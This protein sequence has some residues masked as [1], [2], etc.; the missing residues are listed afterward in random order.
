M[1]NAG[2]LASARLRAR[3]DLVLTSGDD[4]VVVKDPLT[5]E[6]F[7]LGDRER[8]LLEELRRP[9]SLAELTRRFRERFPNERASGRQVMSFCSALAECSLLLI[10]GAARTGRSEAPKAPK[11]GVAWHSL[12]SPL[13]IRLPGFDPT[14]LLNAT[15][16]I[17]RL[18][19]SWAFVALLSI[20]V[21]LVGIAWIGAANEVTTEL[22]RLVDLFQPQHA[23]L[24][25]GAVIITKTWHELG[26][27]LACRRMGAE[28]HE[29]G[30]MLLAFMPCLY[31]DVSDA[32]TLTSRRRRVLV[33]LGGVYFEFLLA[34]AAAGAWLFLAPGPLR[35][36]SMYVVVT[37]TISTLLINLNPLLRFDGYYVLADAWGVS[38]L[39]QRSREALWGGVQRWIRA[40]P[41]TAETPDASPTLLAAY[42]LASTIYSWCL[43]GVI[44]WAVYLGLEAAGFA[45]VGDLLLVLS[46]GGVGLAGVRSARRV[47]PRGHGRS[48]WKPLLRVTLVAALSAGAIAAVLA[49]PLEQSLR[50]PC[51][52]ES[53]SFAEVVARRDGL[54]KPVAAYGDRVSAGALLAQQTDPT[55]EWRRLELI[56]REA[57]LVAQIDGL[58]TR[59][60][61]D[62]QFL[63]EI[64]RLRPTLAEVRRQLRTHK[65][66]A[67]SLTLRA[68]I[69]GRVLPPSER[70][71][72]SI[73]EQ[74]LPTWSGRPLDESNAGCLL[75]SGEVLCRVM[76]DGLRA[77]VLLDEHDCG[78]LNLGDLVRV[79]LHRDPGSIL[80]GHVEQIAPATSDERLSDT[81]MALEQG[82]R[83]SL[84]KGSAYRVT[85][86]IES[87]NAA[88][89]P[90][91]LGTARL[92]TG[93]ETVG[94][95]CLRWLRRVIR[96][97]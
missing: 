78:L 81:E 83:S 13:A 31:C 87:I 52:L 44:L 40:E 25:I 53:E 9:L 30:V 35:V 46:F 8:F 39:H 23:L 79:A 63:S 12:L 32:W 34:L 71:A 29:I 57:T 47:V 6:Y 1:A 5:L 96:F 51:R 7:R 14:R 68:P 64:T 48:E 10:D 59:S 49:I 92:V 15:A 94:Q 42:G 26:H 20:A 33:A 54:L 88:C 61:Q 58:R 97:R 2:K 76:G 28:C 21:L 41:R 60:Q 55:S 84:E 18:A 50:S 70:E 19:F 85:V 43:L 90:G 93:R 75:A 82:M 11:D 56:E 86:A 67:K 89:Q 24:A 77:V 73:D 91:A 17:G 62:A 37:A 36:L 74:A 22:G 66:Q 16:W 3:R 27:A 95:R 45:A 65:E 80:S 69:A 38:N 4:G 72:A